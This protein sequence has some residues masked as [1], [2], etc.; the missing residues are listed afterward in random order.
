M[1]AEA[2]REA[3][4]VVKEARDQQAAP[5]LRRGG[6]QAGRARRR[7]DHRGRPRDRAPDPPRRRGLRRRD[8][9]DP[10]GQPPEVPRR[11]AARPRPPR[12]PRRRARRGRL[13]AFGPGG[14]PRAADRRTPPRPRG[15]REPGGEDPGDARADGDRGRSLTRRPSS[16][17]PAESSASSCA[18]SRPRGCRC[19]PLELEC[20]LIE[21]RRRGRRPGGAAARLRAGRR[22][23]RRSAGY[24]DG[25]VDGTSVA[26]RVLRREELSPIARERLPGPARAK[27]WPQI[28]TVDPTEIDGLAGGAGDP[29]LEACELW[30]RALDE[31]G[32]PLP[33]VEAGLRWLRL[34]PPPPA[35]ATLVHGDF[36]LGN[37]IVDERGPRRGDRLGA[38]PR[39]RPGRGH[40][41]AL[42]PLVAVRQRRAAR[43]PASASSRRSSA[44]YEAAGGTRPDARAPALVGGVRQRQVGGDLRPPGARSPHRRPPEPRARLARAADLRARVGPARELTLT[45]G[46]RIDAGPAHSPRA[47]RRPRGDAVLEVREWVPRERRFQVLVAANV[48]AVVARELRAGAEPSLADARL[49]R[50]LLGREDAADPSPEEAGRRRARGGDSARSDPRRGARRPARW[51]RSRRLR[52]HVA[53]KL[54]VARPGYGD[55]RPG[56]RRR[57]S[58]RGRRPPR[59]PRRRPTRPGRPRARACR[60]PGG[61]ARPAAPARPRRRRRSRAPAP[62]RGPGGR[63]PASGRRRGGGS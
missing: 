28:H 45:G 59:R 10:R 43:S 19:T 46:S 24:A 35:R 51:T 57:G 39:R 8:P 33:A 1:L 60:T 15:S 55:L 36:R 3:E 21:A 22:A 5:D 38:L 32:E 2:K 7:G 56:R 13:A 17:R 44:A 42:H 58:P 40:R 31:I 20:G 37:F 4:R 34:N 49:F 48:C 54:E 63:G 52:E 18:A 29:A 25:Y 47:P 41:L 30:E 9:L 12:R 16:S 11:R 23:A 14:D 6:L 27:R 53:R 50:Q 26:P 61:A 62:A